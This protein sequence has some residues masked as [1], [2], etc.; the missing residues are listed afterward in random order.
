MEL[1]TMNKKLHEVREKWDISEDWRIKLQWK[2]H[3]PMDWAT[4]R[5]LM[6]FPS[7]AE[8]AAV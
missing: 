7:M 2:L 5:T 1:Q 3:K 4:L 8:H 6:P